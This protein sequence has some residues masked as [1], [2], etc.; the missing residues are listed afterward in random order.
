M[1]HLSIITS[2]PAA[3][4][5]VTTAELVTHLRLPSVQDGGKL[6]ELAALINTARGFVEAA[7]GR[8]MA[9]A[10]YRE[11]FTTADLKAD[12]ML[13][14]SRGPVTAI[15]AIRYYPV[16]GSARVV[17]TS[18]P[19]ISALLV[20]MGDMLPGSAFITSSLSSL[21]LYDRPDAF[22]IDYVAGHTIGACPD[23]MKHAVLMLAALWH[24][25]RI[26]TTAVSI[27]ELPFGLGAIIQQQRVGGF[28][29]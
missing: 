17:L 5:P 24:E 1:S 2:T 22:A 3:N 4:S 9:P 19:A 15:T 28:N 27:N 11:L 26:P 12:A 21:S 13:R 8:G 20:E 6:T 10:T 25:E 18:A 7:T 29:G 16:D 23:G 14:F